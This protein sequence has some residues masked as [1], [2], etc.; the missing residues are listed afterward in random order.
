MRRFHPSPDSLSSGSPADGV[1]IIGFALMIFA[2]G[3]P[4]AVYTLN[5]TVPAQ[6]IE[7]VRFSSVSITARFTSRSEVGEWT[8]DR[9]TGDSVFGGPEGPVIVIEMADRT[10]F[11]L[12]V[13]SMMSRRSSAYPRR[14]AA[15]ARIGLRTTRRRSWR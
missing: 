3:G 12:W 13:Q 14:A 15:C 8:A 6:E 1:S 10:F 2:P 11:A 9:P 4:L 7:R 5:R